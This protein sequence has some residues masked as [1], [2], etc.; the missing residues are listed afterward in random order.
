[1]TVARAL[2]D[3]S[4]LIDPPSSLGHFAESVAV[5]TITLA[6]LAYGLHTADPVENSARA[7][8][9]RRILETVEA[10]PYSVAAATLYGALCAA[11]LRAGRSPRARRFDLL[12]ASVAAAENIPLLTRN[13]NDFRGVH[14]RVQIMSVPPAAG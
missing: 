11:V 2:L 4:V 7:L 8:R 6:E 13:P 3:T 9:Y 10:L 1:M 12:I 5:S 14:R